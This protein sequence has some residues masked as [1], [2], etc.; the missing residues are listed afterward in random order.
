MIFQNEIT[1]LYDLWSRISYSK[2]LIVNQ[3]NNKF[4]LEFVL[5]TGDPSS[6]LFFNELQDLTI[7]KHPA[8]SISWAGHWS[9]DGFNSQYKKFKI[10]FIDTLINEKL[11]DNEEKLG[12]YVSG[13]KQC[14]KRKISTF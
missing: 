3:R 5:N 7:H 11:K 4:Q 12:L 1:E 14:I 8:G 13:L 2:L 9:I 6:Q 10:D